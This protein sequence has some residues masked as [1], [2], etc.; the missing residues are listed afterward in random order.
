MQNLQPV[1]RQRRPILVRDGRLS[2]QQRLRA[3]YLR[4]VR[5][6]SADALAQRSGGG[7]PAQKPGRGF[8]LQF[9]P[10]KLCRGCP[11]GSGSRHRARRRATLT[12]AEFG[13]YRIRNRHPARRERPIHRF[14]QQRLPSRRRVCIA[15]TLDKY[16][17]WIDLLRHRSA[18]VVFFSFE[19]D[20]PIPHSSIVQKSAYVYANVHLPE[21][22]LW[23]VGLGYDD[24]RAENLD[25]CKFDP[26]L[27]FQWD[28]SDR[29]RL[30]LAAFRTLEPPVIS[31][32]PIQPT[33]VAGFNQ[34]YDDSDGT[35]AWNYGAAIEARLDRNWFAGFAFS[36][37]Q[38]DEPVLNEDRFAREER[39]DSLYRSYLYWTP[40]TEWALS[41]N[42]SSIPIPEIHA[43]ISPY[44]RRSKR[45]APPSRCAISIR[46]VS[47]LA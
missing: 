1:L 9:R 22:M 6:G 24:H 13:S 40:A 45:G 27:G 31:N 29:L 46:W 5:A 47:S 12:I 8:A 18:I 38:F 32:R 4:C 19:V 14:R 28:I 17:I 34:F 37:R 21:N 15:R 16:Y 33:Q 39:K 44:R 10:E 41:T 23:T 7:N 26:K 3:R 36:G 2:R 25:I 42:S 35:V 20:N 11:S 30:R 43:S